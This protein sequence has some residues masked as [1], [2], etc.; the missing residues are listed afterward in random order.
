MRVQILVAALS[1]CE[2]ACASGS[3]TPSCPTDGTYRVHYE[4]DKTDPG[5]CM[6]VGLSDDVVTVLGSSVSFQSVTGGCTGAFAGCK[7]T[8]KCDGSGPLGPVTMQLSWTFDS[9]GV[10]GLTALGVHQDGG[11]ACSLNLSTTGRRQ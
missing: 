11:R 2:V 7:L 6:P 3:N 10:S 1:A 5:S 9:A 4:F 8:A